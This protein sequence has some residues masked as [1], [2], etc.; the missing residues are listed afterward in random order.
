[1]REGPLTGEGGQLIAP[2]GGEGE[3]GD[4]APRHLHRRHLEQDVEAGH[5]ADD[6]AEVGAERGQARRRCLKNCQLRTE[7]IVLAVPDGKREY[8]LIGI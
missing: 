7:Q 2:V 1:M 3:V 6:G 8:I 4:A 5:Q